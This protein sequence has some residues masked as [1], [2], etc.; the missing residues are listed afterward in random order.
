MHA[1]WDWAETFFF[2]V[3]DSGMPASGHLLNTAMS[4]SKWMTGGTV[5]PEGSVVGLMVVSAVIGLLF[6]RF[7]KKPR[8]TAPLS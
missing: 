3:A 1:S 6:L 5:G 7:G 4:G 2:G 8:L